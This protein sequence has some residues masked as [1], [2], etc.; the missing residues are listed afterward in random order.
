M[1]K[2][3]IYKF[4]RRP[5]VFVVNWKIMEWKSGHISIAGHQDR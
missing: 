2:L 3:D 5:Q 1:G 4:P